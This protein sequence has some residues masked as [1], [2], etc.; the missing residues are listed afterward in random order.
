M[1]A[2]L[3]T[4]FPSLLLVQQPPAPSIDA[5]A[6][7]LFDGR[8]GCQGEFAN[9]RKIE[10]D[11]N[12]EKQMD[13][14]WLAYTHTDRPP[15]RYRAL[16]YWGTDRETGN[17][18]MLLVD[19]GGGARLFT[20]QGWKNG[21]VTFERAP[22][23]GQGEH[24]ERFRFEKQSEASFRMTYEVRAGDSWRLGDFIVCKK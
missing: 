9:G 24:A 7:A 19:I 12:F 8:F 1:N 20:S 16:G 15:N 4:L 5:E 13:G 2:A 21:A 3:L 14:K 10:A 18:V 6:A 22:L 17:F 23:P 11:V